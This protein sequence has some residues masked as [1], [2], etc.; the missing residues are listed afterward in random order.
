MKL[1]ILANVIGTWVFGGSHKS[2]SI[3][4]AEHT[5]NSYIFLYR[6]I[7]YCWFSLPTK[8]K[9]Q[10]QQSLIVM[11][12]W[13]LG[14]LNGAVTEES[15]LCQTNRLRFYCMFD[16]IRYPN[17]Q[18][19]T[20]TACIIKLCINIPHIFNLGLF[21][22]QNIMY[23]KTVLSIRYYFIHNTH[24]FYFYLIWSW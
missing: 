21:I 19:R 11:A 22:E 6:Y 18:I 14:T 8:N 5:H 2:K 1:L 24:C 13:S 4:F 17:V 9:I 20:H 7:I 16:L 12:P 15:P 10:I 23:G 3:F